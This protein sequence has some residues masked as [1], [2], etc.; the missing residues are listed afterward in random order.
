M[1]LPYFPS[2]WSEN[3]VLLLMIIIN[4]IVIIQSV[5]VFLSKVRILGFCLHHE[6]STLALLTFGAR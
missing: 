3:S 6:F 4:K 5:F 1:L 2:F